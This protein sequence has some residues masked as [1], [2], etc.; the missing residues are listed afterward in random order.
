MSFRKSVTNAGSYSQIRRNR[1]ARGTAAAGAA[2][3]A[4]SPSPSPRATNRASW[5]LRGGLA[6]VFAYAAGAGLVDPGHFD[7]YVPVFVRES[8]GPTFFLG[9]FSAYEM[10][11][12]I[13]FLTRRYAYVA[14]V[15]AALSLVAI[16]VLNLNEFG[17]LFRNVPIA[18]AALA[19]AEHTRIHDST[20]RALIARRDRARAEPPPDA[21][22]TSAVGSICA[23]G[24]R[25]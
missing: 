3:G 18:C 15:L 20:R 2:V 16:V 14:S 23:N 7:Q 13:A 5:F 12:A 24:S 11:L 25:P 22:G 10:L 6:F 19:L 8:V 1:D 17:V 21:T 4:A 9:L